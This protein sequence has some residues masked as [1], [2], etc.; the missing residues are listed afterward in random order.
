MKNEAVSVKKDLPVTI[1]PAN[2]LFVQMNEWNNR[3]AK[4]A[5]ELFEARGFTV[6]QSLDDW[7]AAERELLLPVAL[8]VK[9]TK[10]EFV[11]RA[12]AP[13]F[14][15]KDLDVLLDGIHLVIQGNR[16]IIDKQKNADGTISSDIKLQQ[17]YRVI[18]LP[19]PVEAEMVQ[20]EFKNGVL[21]LTL[22]KAKEN[23]KAAA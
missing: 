19:E 20:A 5:Y 15:A 9:D 10:D 3:V 23:I 7:F 6:G 18:E 8:E 2:E 13:G 22:P 1:T 11:V 14:E 4:R 21:E 16:K 17:I 12:E